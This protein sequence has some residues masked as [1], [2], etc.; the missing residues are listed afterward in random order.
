MWDT[1]WSWRSLHAHL[2]WNTFCDLRLL[3]WLFPT[4][5]GDRFRYRQKQ[6]NVLTETK[7]PS[8]IGICWTLSGRRVK[9]PLTHVS[10]FSSKRMISC[11]VVNWWEGS[12]SGSAYSNWI[13]LLFAGSFVDD[14]IIFRWITYTWFLRYV[15]EYNRFS[16]LLK[17]FKHLVLWDVIAYCSS[18]Q[19]F[20]YL[21]GEYEVWE[22]FYSAFLS[23]R[24]IVYITLESELIH[25]E[26]QLIIVP[27]IKILLN[28]AVV[29][30]GVLL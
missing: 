23:R 30:W 21:E 27:S 29:Q 7:E 18:F 19:R 13:S 17:S 1:W 3:G 20:V 16:W 12:S 4:R 28:G 22:W 26:R 11:T 6:C 14:N 15:V 10:W 25:V 8:F 24:Y 9:M 2:L 5:L